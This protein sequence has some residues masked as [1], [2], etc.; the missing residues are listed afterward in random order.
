MKNRYYESSALCYAYVDGYLAY[1][2]RSLSS[3]HTFPTRSV[4]NWK[5]YPTRFG[6][7]FLNPLLFLFLI[8]LNPLLLISEW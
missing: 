8:R 3:L 1:H 2:L 6:L 5:D 7:D 4:I